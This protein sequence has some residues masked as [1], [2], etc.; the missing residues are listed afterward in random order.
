MRPAK[1]AKLLDVGCAEGYFLHLAR[2]AGHEVTGLDFNPL[3]L[4]MARRVFGIASVYQYRVEELHDRFPGTLF[5]VVTIFEVLEHTANPYQTVCSI[6]SVLRP[7]GQLFL[8]V[9]GSRRWPRLFHPEVDAP[10]HH[11]T[12]WTEEA[13]VSLLERAEFR[14]HTVQAKP[15]EVDELSMHLKWRLHQAVRKLRPQHPSGASTDEKAIVT[16]KQGGHRRKDYGII[17][18]FARAGLRSACWALRLN[19]RAGGFTLFAHCDKA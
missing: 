2:Q 5:D 8:S 1:G 16:R 11:L 12:L 15:L 13:L 6:Q 7:G 17:R 10:P 9:P 4:E 18:D 14:V 3:S 19:P